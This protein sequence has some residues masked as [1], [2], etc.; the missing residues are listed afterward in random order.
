MGVNCACSAAGGGRRGAGRAGRE[1]RA[2]RGQVWKVWAAGE[3]GGTVEGLHSLLWG[4]V[5]Y[6]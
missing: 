3:L 1:G 6:F 2:G 4:L 5:E